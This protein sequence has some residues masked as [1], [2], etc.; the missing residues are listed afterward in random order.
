MN[1]FERRDSAK[2]MAANHFAVRM[3]R[4]FFYVD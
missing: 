2:N 3:P 1:E 4:F